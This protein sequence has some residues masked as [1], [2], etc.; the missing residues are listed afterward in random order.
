MKASDIQPGDQMVNEDD[1]VAY[2]VLSVRTRV[3]VIAVV[4]WADGG[5]EIRTW[6]ADAEAP[7]VR[8]GN[9]DTDRP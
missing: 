9:D 2:E 8:G 4:E 5:R 1:S 7:L 3:H 6:D